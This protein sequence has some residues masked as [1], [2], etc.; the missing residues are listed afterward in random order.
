[1]QEKKGKIDRIVHKYMRICMRPIELKRKKLKINLK[2]Q[3]FPSFLL[4]IKSIYIYSIY[5]FSVYIYT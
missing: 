3:F 1:M 5:I 2:V 4:T